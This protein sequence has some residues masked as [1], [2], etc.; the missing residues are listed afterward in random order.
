M[1]S[2]TKLDFSL[3]LNNALKHVKKEVVE[4]D[5][6][7][8]PCEDQDF[9]VP[10]IKSERIDE[11]ESDLST[12]PTGN[13]YSET[14]LTQP[15]EEQNVEFSVIKNETL[16][17]KSD[18]YTKQSENCVSEKSS[19]V[20]LGHEESNVKQEIERTNFKESKKPWSLVVKLKTNNSS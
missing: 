1:M 3:E 14:D 4:P 13:C 20:S 10:M 6:V 18:L 5:L 17:M 12:Q 2:D 16:E 8:Q 15:C 11:D 19:N 7:T 9:Q